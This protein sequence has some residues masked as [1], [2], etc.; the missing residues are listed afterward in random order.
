MMQIWE[1]KVVKNLCQVKTDS[2]VIR[3]Q[4]ILYAESWLDGKVTKKVKCGVGVPH[5]FHSCHNKSRGFKEHDSQFG[6]SPLLS[7][8]HKSDSFH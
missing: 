1:R 3:P 6:T 7:L 2:T 8:G 5:W 4:R